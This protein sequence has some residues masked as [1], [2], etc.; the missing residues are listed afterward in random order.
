MAAR[1]TAPKAERWADKID[2]AYRLL[3]E[4]QREARDVTAYAKG[5]DLSDAQTVSKHVARAGESVREA[6][7]EA[8]DAARRVG[9]RKATA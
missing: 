6:R 3:M 8:S 4:V 9:R 7:D 1:M 5:G 2:R